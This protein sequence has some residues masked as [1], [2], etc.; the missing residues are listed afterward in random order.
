MTINSEWSSGKPEGHF[1]FTPFRYCLHLLSISSLVCL[2]IDKIMKIKSFGIVGWI[3]SFLFISQNNNAQVGI[4]TTPHASA[5]LE[6][7]S[8]TG[9]LLL[10]RLSNTNRNLITNPPEGLTIFNTTFDRFEYSDGSTWKSLLTNEF[11]SRNGNYVYTLND[12]GLGTAAPD[13]KL[14]VLGNIK[15]RGDLMLSRFSGVI[16]NINF[17]YTGGSSD[18][19]TQG[20]YFKIGGNHRSFLT[21]KH[22]DAAGED[23][24]RFGFY[25]GTSAEIKSSGEFIMN[26][27]GNPTLQ[28]RTLGIDKG[29]IQLAGDDLRVGTNSS[30]TTG[31]THF[32][33]N[34]GNRISV[35]SNGYMKIGSGT[36]TERLDV[37]GNILCNADTVATGNLITDN[38]TIHNEVRKQVTTGT[39]NLIPLA[40]GYVDYDGTILNATSNASVTRVSEGVY[41]ISVSGISGSC[42]I[43]VN[44]GE[45]TSAAYYT[46][47]KCRVVNYQDLT[48][49]L[50]TPTKVDCKFYFVIFQ[51]YI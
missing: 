3:C 50:D 10:P 39:Y 25:N 11:W 49:T 36:P 40:Y 29:F 19:L 32:R 48:E 44:G 34:G 42:T 18:N 28:M 20:F 33:L 8:T 23:K 46:T 47:G 22:A 2:K 21:F 24:F 12:V 45:T 27:A 17:N 7:E 4:G 15:L 31:Q 41:E 51:P 1:N 9:G 16:N 5:Q 38:I 14:D 6:I 43:I 26:T 37:D 13:A 35:A 30:N